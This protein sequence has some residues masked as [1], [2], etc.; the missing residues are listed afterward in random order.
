MSYPDMRCKASPLKRIGKG[1]LNVKHQ[2]VNFIA[3]N[4]AGSVT[5]N[6]IA[7]ELFSNQ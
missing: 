2:C 4:S 6:E 7:A 3:G 1:A 5:H